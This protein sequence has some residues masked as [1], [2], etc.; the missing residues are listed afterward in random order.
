MTQWSNPMFDL[1]YL[2]STSTT[3]D[4]RKDHLDKILQHYHTTF[5]AITE[6]LNCAVPNWSY[7]QFTA[8]FERTRLVGLL[9]GMCT[10]QGTLS[11]TG[12]KMTSNASSSFNNTNSVVR[13]I[14]S[15]A[16]KL[17][18]LL[19]SQPSFQ[20]IAKSAFKKMFE[21]FAHELIEGKNQLMND[22]VLDLLIDANENGL[23]DSLCT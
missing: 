2:L 5:T 11:K 8:E 6:S 21:P 22:R 23:L 13:K 4:V 15:S 9:T 1:H 18:V 20:F 3:G 7:E 19:I 16:A 10:V 17:F 12:E 14:K